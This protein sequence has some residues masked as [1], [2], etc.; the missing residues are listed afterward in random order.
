MI[1]S[2]KEFVPFYNVVKGW[3][4]VGCWFIYDI[5]TLNTNPQC[6]LRQCH[7][8]DW[9]TLNIPRPPRPTEGLILG[10]IVQKVLTL[11]Q[12]SSYGNIV[13]GSDE[14]HYRIILPVQFLASQVKFALEIERVSC[15]FIF[16]NDAKVQ[17]GIWGHLIL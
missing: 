16:G 6:S 1:P 10:L 3:K 11:N 14:D 4:V 2:Y 15:S 17:E 5:I 8:P 7:S 13:K 9:F 12:F